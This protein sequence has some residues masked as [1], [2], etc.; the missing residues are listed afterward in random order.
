VPLVRDVPLARALYELE[1]NQEIPEELF[2]SVAEVL[3]FVYKL[4]EERGEVR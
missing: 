2:R 3:R 4:A 1:V